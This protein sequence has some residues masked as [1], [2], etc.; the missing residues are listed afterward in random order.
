MTGTNTWFDVEESNQPEFV[1]NYLGFLT[2]PAL[3]A[4]NGSLRWA[5]VKRESN[6]YVGWVVC[7]SSGKPITYAGGGEPNKF[8]VSCT[9]TYLTKA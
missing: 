8:S 6:T 2:S 4:V 1:F 9:G 5:Q 7:Y 3:K